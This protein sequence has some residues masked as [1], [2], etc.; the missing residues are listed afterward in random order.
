MAIGTSTLS[1]ENVQTILQRTEGQFCDMKACAIA[2]SKLS[3]TLSALANADGGE[4]F[5][6]IGQNEDGSFKWDG[7]PTDEAAN[8]HIQVIDKHF[9]IGHITRCAFLICDALPGKILHIEVEKSGE[10]REGSDGTPYVRRGA[11]NLP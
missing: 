9:P 11:Q 8:A 7:F 4:V 3:R 5:L 10:I 1:P 6:G 2:P